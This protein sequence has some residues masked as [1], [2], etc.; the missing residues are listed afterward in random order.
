MSGDLDALLR[1]YPMIGSNDLHQITASL[2]SIA[3]SQASIAGNLQ[4]LTDYWLGKA[5]G[6]DAVFAPP[7]TRPIP[8]EKES[9]MASVK[10]I[11]ASSVTRKSAAP[12]GAAKPKAAPGVF[13]LLDNE[14]DTFTVMG[15]DA[16][17]NQVDISTVA[18]LTVSSDAPTILTVSP[19]VGMTSA[20]QAVGPTGAANVICVATWNDAS[21]GPFTLNQPITVSGTAATGLVVNFGTPTIVPPT[22]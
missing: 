7:T 2:E 5:V 10:C 11:K 12:A 6:I 16:G 18:T 13:V 3:S 15:V 19:P 4:K 8:H 17:G 1:G 22:P 20:V 14:D 21:I 9:T